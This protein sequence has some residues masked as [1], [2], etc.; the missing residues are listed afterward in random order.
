MRKAQRDV[1]LPTV[2]QLRRELDY[3]PATGILTRKR[4]AHLAGKIAGSVRKDGYRAVG[5]CGKLLLANRV[6][7]AI[8]NGKWP[9]HEVDHRNLSHDDNRLDNLR[10]AT[11]SQNSCN[12]P[13]R[14]RVSG[15]KGVYPNGKSGWM[16]RI[17]VAGVDHYL[18]T[19]PTK[20]AAAAAYARG[21]ALYH[22]EFGR[23][24]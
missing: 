1:P 2:E 10:E 14:E 22:G 21:S 6:G 18:G 12:N 16:S 8:H 11:P 17:M 24:A 15:I 5:V 9:E 7:W 19:Y 3:D 4:P 23:L 13:G 20:E